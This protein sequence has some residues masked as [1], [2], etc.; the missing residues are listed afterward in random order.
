MEM[1]ARVFLM[2]LN[3]GIEI[4]CVILVVLAAR[5]LLLKF[6]KKYSYFLWI[7]VAVR[8]IVPVETFSLFPAARIPL[9]TT[10]KFSRS[11]NLLKWF[12]DNRN[13]AGEFKPSSSS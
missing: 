9:V 11:R 12:C 8:V 3:R 5:L 4:S 1:L 13:R 7:L 10:E 6:P 2:V